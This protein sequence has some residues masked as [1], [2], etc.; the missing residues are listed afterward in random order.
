MVAEGA[1]HIVPRV[2]PVADGDSVVGMS[3]SRGLVRRQVGQTPGQAGNGPWQIPHA[4]TGDVLFVQVVLF[5]KVEP[6]QLGLGLGQ[7]QYRG[8]AR[9][10]RLDLGVA[11]F[12]AADVLGTAGGV[13]AR[14]YLRDKASLGLQGL[15]HVTIEGTGSYV[16][17]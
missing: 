14:Y 13:V 12:L 7:G 15:P 17:V 1:L 16:T 6:L 10:N 4:A 11:Q 5:Q 2:G 8:V 3:G 9:C